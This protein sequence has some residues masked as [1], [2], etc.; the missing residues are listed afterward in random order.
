MIRVELKPCTIMG[1]NIKSC[2]LISVLTAVDC[3]IKGTSWGGG[4]GGGGPERYPLP[5]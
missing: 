3:C 1:A 5:N 2:V 4:G